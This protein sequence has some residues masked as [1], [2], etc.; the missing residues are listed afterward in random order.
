M[1]RSRTRPASSGRTGTIPPDPRATVPRT[2]ENQTSDETQESITRR[3]D[4]AFGEAPGGS[5]RRPG[6]VAEQVTGLATVAAVPVETLDQSQVQELQRTRKHLHHPRPGRGEATTFGGRRS[7]QMGVNRR[8]NGPEPVRKK[9]QHAITSG[10]GERAGTTGQVLHPQRLRPLLHRRGFESADAAPTDQSA[11]GVAAGAEGRWPTFQ[12]GGFFEGQDSERLRAA[13]TSESQPPPPKENQH[14]HYH[15]GVPGPP[16]AQPGGPPQVPGHGPIASPVRQ[17]SPPRTSTSQPR[18]SS[19]SS[20]PIGTAGAAAEYQGEKYGD[21]ID[22]GGLPGCGPGLRGGAARRN[23]PRRTGEA[24]APR[25]QR[26]KAAERKPGAARRLRYLKPPEKPRGSGAGR[27]APR[28]TPRRAGRDERTK[29]P[30]RTQPRSAGNASLTDGRVQVIARGVLASE[31]V[32]RVQRRECLP[33]TP[34]KPTRRHRHAGSSVGS[35]A[36]RSRDRDR[37]T[38]GTPRSGRH[39]PPPE[40]GRRQTPDRHGDEH[41]SRRTTRPS[42]LRNLR[43]KKGEEAAR[44][45]TRPSPSRQSPPPYPPRSRRRS[46][47]TDSGQGIT[48]RTR[49]SAARPSPT[50]SS[51]ARPASVATSRRFNAKPPAGPSRTGRVPLPSR[52]LGRLQRT[53][54]TGT[55]RKNVARTAAQLTYPE[56]AP[57]GEAHQLAFQGEPGAWHG[58]TDRGRAPGGDPRGARPGP[59]GTRF[60][61]TRRRASTK[62]RPRTS[63]PRDV[64]AQ[65]GAAAGKPSDAAIHGGLRLLAFALPSAGGGCE[66]QRRR[67]GRPTGDGSRRPQGGAERH[68][69]GTDDERRARTEGEPGPRAGYIPGGSLQTKK[70]TATPTPG[71]QDLRFNPPGQRA[72]R[73]AAAG[74]RSRFRRTPAAPPPESGPITGPGQDRPGLRP[75]TPTGETTEPATNDGEAGQRTSSGPPG[76]PPGAGVAHRAYT[77]PR[78]DGPGVKVL[79][80]HGPVLPERHRDPSAA[81]HKI[82]IHPPGLTGSPAAASALQDGQVA[83]ADATAPRASQRSRT[84]SEPKAG[85]LSQSTAS[86]RSPRY[87]LHLAFSNSPVGKARVRKVKK[88]K[89]KRPPPGGGRAGGNPAAGSGR[90]QGPIGSAPL[91]RR[92]PHATSSTPAGGL[93]VPATGSRTPGP[94]DHRRSPLQ[95]DGGP[96]L[97]RRRAASGPGCRNKGPGISKRDQTKRRKVITTT[98]R[99]GS[100][101]RQ[102]NEAATGRRRGHSGRGD[103]V[104][105]PNRIRRSQTPRGRRNLQA[106]TRRRGGTLHGPVAGRD[107]GGS[108]P[109]ARRRQCAPRRPT[110]PAGLGGTRREATRP[111][112]VAQHR[113]CRGYYRRAGVPIPGI[114]AAGHPHRARAK[115]RGRSKPEGAQAVHAGQERPPRQIPPP[116][117]QRPPGRPRRRTQGTRSKSTRQL[118]ASSTTRTARRPDG[119]GRGED[120]AGEPGAN[121]AKGAE[122]RREGAG[123][124]GTTTGPPNQ[125]NRAGGALLLRRPP[126]Y[127]LHVQR[128]RQPQKRENIGPHRFLLHRPRHRPLRGRLSPPRP[129]D[130]KPSATS[131]APSSQKRDVA[132]RVPDISTTP[133]P[134]SDRA[135]TWP[136]TPQRKAKHS[137]LALRDPQTAA[138]VAQ[139]E[140]LGAV[141]AAIKAA[142][143]GEDRT[144]QRQRQGRSRNQVHPRRKE[145]RSST[146][147]PSA[148]TTSSAGSR[149]TPT[150]TTNKPARH[151]LPPGLL[152]PNGTLPRLS[153]SPPRRRRPGSRRQGE[154]K[155]EARPSLL[156]GRKRG[157]QGLYFFGQTAAG[158]LLHVNNLRSGEPIEPSS[159][160]T[161]AAREPSTGHHLPGRSRGRAKVPGTREAKASAARTFTGDRA[162]R[163]VD[164][165][166]PR[167][168]QQEPSAS[169]LAEAAGPPEVRPANRTGGLRPSPPKK[170][171][172]PPTTSTTAPRTPPPSSPPFIGVGGAQLLHPPRDVPTP[173][174]VPARATQR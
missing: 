155:R 169:D 33:K 9:V 50:N 96:P 145:R 114:S 19:A 40:A 4:D 103:P 134:R 110:W 164:K 97:K 100:A 140:A 106:P 16:R 46:A 1:G 22:P 71:G 129:L 159:R 34:G 81:G 74:R 80:D 156:A 168:R 26:A 127:F 122:E 107:Q 117:T 135:Q 77:L 112:A 47:T 124:L 52:S 174:R 105:R 70:G 10:A 108:S 59:L 65:G 98:T 12:A 53:P 25:S 23:S 32:H 43:P 93:S 67:P 62:P 158:L 109:S 68:G 115:E 57:T 2:S 63:A 119:G 148:S 84:S 48:P 133:A 111:G 38:E 113:R 8:R 72:T 143:K 18:A 51:S 91:R 54:R 141:R 79:P 31:Q 172:R 78:A 123:Q 149:S 66:E 144:R 28:G 21:N 73:F 87:A 161:H 17:R 102:E 136:T 150:S 130:E 139:I 37:S 165:G 157:H 153:S 82:Q 20:R 166:P 120:A 15:P 36:W 24:E 90:A 3:A 132:G 58:S 154:T 171:A 85:E 146:T 94:A 5:R 116:S 64:Q 42:L 142:G 92:S 89:A 30:G 45:A 83:G 163:Q 6:E 137:A 88:G 69:Q 99:T 75:T 27:S 138:T 56:R 160:Q 170:G 167:R 60:I 29:Q 61:G 118:A 14:N 125:K 49:S 152:L 41:G 126:L 101:D 162:I 7:F 131:T 86:G 147:T 55:G 121:R 39:R 13:A 35:P 128:E 151:H 104:R 11:E 44:K 173:S 76:R 95:P